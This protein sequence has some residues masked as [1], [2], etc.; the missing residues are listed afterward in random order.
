MQ[1]AIPDVLV[2]LVAASVFAVI[3]H[4]PRRRYRDLGRLAPLLAGRCFRPQN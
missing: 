2:L 4:P 1:I 3:K